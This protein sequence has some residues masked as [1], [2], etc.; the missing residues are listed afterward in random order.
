MTLSDLVH[1]STLLLI[2]GGALYESVDHGGELVLGLLL[3]GAVIRAGKRG[4]QTK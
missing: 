2:A 1:V 3:C 4:H